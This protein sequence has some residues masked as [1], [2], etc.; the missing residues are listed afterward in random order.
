MHVWG[1]PDWPEVIAD[2]FLRNGVPALADELIEVVAL[3][4][5]HPYVEG[6]SR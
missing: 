4:A 5:V 6:P 3:R 2:W 1:N